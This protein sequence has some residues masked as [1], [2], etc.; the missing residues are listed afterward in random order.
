MIYKKKKNKNNKYYYIKINEKGKKQIISKAEYDN[1]MKDGGGKR[2]AE[3]EDKRKAEEEG[4]FERIGYFLRDTLGKITG[5]PNQHCCTVENKERLFNFLKLNDNDIE[6]V[7]LNEKLN[8]C[9]LNPNVR[10][11][12]IKETEKIPN[13]ATRRNE[14]MREDDITEEETKKLKVKY[15]KAR[16]WNCAETARTLF[17][18]FTKNQNIKKY[19]YSISFEKNKME[20]FISDIKDLFRIKFDG[21]Y[22]MP[23]SK[24]SSSL[25]PISKKSRV[26]PSEKNELKISITYNNSTYNNRKKNNNI[27]KPL[28]IKSFF[29][30]FKENK[31][32]TYFFI[33]IR[34][35]ENQKNRINEYFHHSLLL[36]FNPGN[37]QNVNQ[38]NVKNNEDS[39]IIQSWQEIMPPKV[40]SP[41]DFDTF[42]DG[43]NEITGKLQT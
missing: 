5:N 31:K 16:W 22:A 9:S 35:S 6:T 36:I 23:F 41:F 39:I 42:I 15:P 33:N 30:S 25:S 14:Q 13:N 27:Q 40:S 24:G 4:V 37:Q 17:K 26:I 10:G 43:I 34:L 7:E 32:R 2:K 12:V 20:Q 38:K 19:E 11:K 3:D 18:H 28:K 21:P 8:M 1:N 29:E